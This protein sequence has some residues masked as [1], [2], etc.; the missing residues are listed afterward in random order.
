MSASKKISMS[1]AVRLA[2]K[3]RFQLALHLIAVLQ[4]ISRIIAFES[5]YSDQ[6]GNF[7]ERHHGHD[8]VSVARFVNTH[9]SANTRVPNARRTPLRL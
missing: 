5:F 2:G 1:S 7:P 9:G 4:H 3:A 8:N 6:F